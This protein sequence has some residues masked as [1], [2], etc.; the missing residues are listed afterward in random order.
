MYMYIAVLIFTRICFAVDPLVQTDTFQ[1]AALQAPEVSAMS[2]L[3]T[4]YPENNYV[5]SSSL[6]CGVT[7]AQGVL[8]I[9]N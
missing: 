3:L 4:S 6:L 2:I 8:F 7:N 9:I 1:K 5:L